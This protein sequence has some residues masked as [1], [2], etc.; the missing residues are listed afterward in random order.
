MMLHDGCLNKLLLQ[1]SCARRVRLSPDL[2][3][4]GCVPAVM[5]QR[6]ISKGRAFTNEDVS[7]AA[8]NREYKTKR[9]S[10]ESNFG[11]KLWYRGH[12]RPITDNRSLRGRGYG[13][14]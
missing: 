1:A 5:G 12:I 10:I 7:E 14:L 11:S 3:V 9:V 13:S 2:W 4:V 8:E 6:R